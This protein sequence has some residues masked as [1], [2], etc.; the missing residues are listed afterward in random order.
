MLRCLAGATIRVE[1]LVNYNF[2]ILKR[3]AVTNLKEDITE[4]KLT[5]YQYNYS[6]SKAIGLALQTI[7]Q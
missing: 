7:L 1:N 2:V 4:R 6:T 5:I 3:I